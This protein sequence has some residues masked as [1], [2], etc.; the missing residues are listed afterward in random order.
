[1]FLDAGELAA[2]WGVPKSQVYRLTRDGVIPH[3]ALGKYYRY[4]L[5]AIEAWEDGAV[6]QREAA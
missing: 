2:R 3:I 4:K 1:V 5:A 6:N